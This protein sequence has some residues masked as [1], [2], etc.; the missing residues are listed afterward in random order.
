MITSVLHDVINKE[1]VVL[2]ASTSYSVNR[3]EQEDIDEV[4]PLIKEWKLQLWVSK[5]MFMKMRIVL[6]IIRKI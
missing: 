3:K 2:C 6:A 1:E 4:F 5:H